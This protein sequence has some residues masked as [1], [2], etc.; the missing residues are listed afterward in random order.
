LL[1]L[2]VVPH[3]LWQ[4]LALLLVLALLSLPLPAL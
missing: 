1:L 4:T 2:P 3:E